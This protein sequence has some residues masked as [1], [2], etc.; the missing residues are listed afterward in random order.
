MKEKLMFTLGKETIHTFTFK[1]NRYQNISENN[2]IDKKN[3]ILPHLSAIKNIS[4]CL[5]IEQNL[6]T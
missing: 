5:K 4:N 2:L 6:T 1:I 3:I